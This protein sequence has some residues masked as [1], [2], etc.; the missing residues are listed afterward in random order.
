MMKYKLGDQFAVLQQFRQ[1][2]QDPSI[3][4]DEMRGT[5]GHESRLAHGS[6][7]Q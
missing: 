1:I 7:L 5:A 6:K 4:V 3:S 2:Q